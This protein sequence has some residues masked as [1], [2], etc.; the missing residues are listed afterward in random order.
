MGDHAQLRPHF[1]RRLKAAR[2][3]HRLS[4]CPKDSLVSSNAL[5][6]EHLSYLRFSCTLFDL[7]PLLCHSVDH[8]ASFRRPCHPTRTCYSSSDYGTSSDYNSSIDC[9]ASSDHASI[10]YY[11]SSSGYDTSS[12][13]PGIRL[14]GSNRPWQCSHQCTSGLQPRRLV[15]RLAVHPFDLED[16]LAALHRRLHADHVG[17][18]RLTHSIM[19]TLHQTRTSSSLLRLTNLP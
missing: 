16:L 17:T 7:T 11:E 5:Q 12:V 6:A 10:S 15:R 9:D 14:H 18:T 13:S 19:L 8:L 3:L 2:L 1:I 4:F